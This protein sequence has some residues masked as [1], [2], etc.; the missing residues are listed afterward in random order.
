MK[1]EQKKLLRDALVASLVAAAP[2]SL[3]LATL[4]GAARSAGFR[5]DEDELEA[6]LGYIE[7]KGLTRV[8][9]ETLSAGVR[10]WEATSDGVDYAESE[11][12]A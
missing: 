10:R 9:R 5:I 12:L 3:P 8:T 11:G 7:G 2:V 1:A 4:M 6:H